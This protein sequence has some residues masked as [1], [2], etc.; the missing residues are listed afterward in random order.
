MMQ[1]SCSISFSPGKMGYPVYSSARM[2][3]K[4]D[5]EEAHTDRDEH[6]VLQQQRVLSLSLDVH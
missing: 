6:L 1:A 3:P 4:L 5:I 2:Q